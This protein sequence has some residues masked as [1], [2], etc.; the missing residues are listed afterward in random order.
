M[1][2][3]ATSTDWTLI[4]GVGVHTVY[5]KFKNNYGT[6]SVASDA[7]ELKLAQAEETQPA[8]GA[9]ELTESEPQSTGL[10]LGAQV[11]LNLSKRL[12]G[13]LLLQV[14]QKGAIWYVDTNNYQ[15]YQVTWANALSLFK[16][17]A[18]GISDADLAKIPTA[19]SGQVGDWS[20]KNR[21]KGK[22][23]LQ[24]EQSG[25]IWYVDP[26]GYRHSVT[27]NN[28]MDLFK[29][30]ALGITDADLSKIANGNLNSASDKTGEVL[31]EQTNR[32]IA[33]RLKGKLLLQVEQGG[34]IWYVDPNSLQR[35]NVTWAN[36]LPLFIK[37]SLG[38][39][40]TDLS[41]IPVKGTASAG[42]ASIRERLK[43][44]LLLQVQ[45]GGA[46]WYIDDNGYRHNVTWN[47]LMPLFQSLAL[48]ITNIDLSKIPVGSLE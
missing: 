14:E 48:G 4:D 1:D 2:K 43:G 38:I 5:V 15:K 41:K 46:I 47:N 11:D 27:W 9:E 33:T 31:G 13:K 3:Y 8:P 29:K 28:L 45:Q 21:L 17:L 12:K 44:K 42:N 39:N 35:Y 36:A 26:D 18:L 19:G 32:S 20:M 30:L 23:L 24:V 22:L 10:V 37:L 40:D 7:I 25:A 34:A 16:K 6:T